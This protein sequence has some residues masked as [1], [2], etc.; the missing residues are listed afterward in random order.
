MTMAAGLLL[1][2][3]GSPATPKRCQFSPASPYNAPDAGCSWVPSCND[4]CPA[5]SSQVDEVPA[6][7]VR[8]GGCL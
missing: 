1:A 6:G 2:G 7:C 4:T 5:N 8:V 3:C